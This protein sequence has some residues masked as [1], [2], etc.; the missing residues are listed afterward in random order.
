MLLS[1]VRRATGRNFLA[2]FLGLGKL[3]SG[4]LFTGSKAISHIRSLGFGYRTQLMYADIRMLRGML[5]TTGTYG[6]MPASEFPAVTN[7]DRKSVV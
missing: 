6:D 1:V 2:E 5:T 4:E 7:V 3:P